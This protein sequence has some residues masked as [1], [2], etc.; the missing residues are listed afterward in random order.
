MANAMLAQR[1]SSIN[2]IT[3]LCEHSEG[4][5]IND[6]RQILMSDQRIGDKFLQPSVGF[7][8]SCFDKDV[9]SLVFILWQR[10]MLQQ[11]KYWQ[12]VLDINDMQKKRLAKVVL[13]HVRNGVV[14]VF[15]F[16]Y[17][18]NT[19]DTRSTPVC[20]LVTELAKAGL[21]V[22][23]HDPQVTIE[24]FQFE[25]EQQGHFF[26]PE[27]N[28]NRRIEFCGADAEKACSNSEAIILCTEWDQFLT[29]NY[30]SLQK[31]MQPNPCLFDFRCYV[32]REAMKKVFSRV[33]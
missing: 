21:T 22:K 16:S 30:P 14:S 33:Y 25:M 3:E 24:G 8:G 7:G 10:G 31:H 23:V 29:Y 5:D 19:S 11:A 9:A 1:V 4:T 15:G 13:N 17:K 12:G 2:S 27:D 26:D 28:E 20:T 32:D 18:K 6:V